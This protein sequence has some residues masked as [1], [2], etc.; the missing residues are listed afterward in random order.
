MSMGALL[1]AAGTKGK[2]MILPHGKVMLHQ[3]S[4]GSGQSS[5]IEIHAS[6]IIDL[7]KSLDRILADR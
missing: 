3:V 2:R 1:L 7:R 5:D 6:E 4:A